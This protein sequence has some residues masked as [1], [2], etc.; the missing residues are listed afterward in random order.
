MRKA[1]IFIAVA[2]VL[3]LSALVLSY[4]NFTS[5]RKAAY[6]EIS[7]MYAGFTLKKE[8]EA[9]YQTTESLRKTLLDS[10]G[11]K[12]QVLG[13]SIEHSGRKDQAAIE[14]F[15]RLKEEYKLKQKQFSDDNTRLSGEYSKQIFNQMNQY[16]SDY[17]KQNKYEYIL[18]ANS[19]GSIMYANEAKNITDDVLA[20][21]NERY[22]GKRK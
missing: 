4:L 6:V 5:S 7:R 3:S 22:E 8:L 14:E 20:Y 13:N 21:M 12:I 19:E 11:L 9:K 2:T 18:G 17:G 16:V 10:I 15:Y 1:Y